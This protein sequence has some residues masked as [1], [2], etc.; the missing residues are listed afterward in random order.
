[1][2]GFQYIVKLAVY[3][4]CVLYIYA[5]GLS[6]DEIQHL[7]YSN[8]RFMSKANFNSCK[9]PRR[10]ERKHTT[11]ECAD[12]RRLQARKVRERCWTE[13]RTKQQTYLGSFLSDSFP[14]P[15]CRH[16]FRAR[17]WEYREGNNRRS[18]RKPDQGRAGRGG[19]RSS[20]RETAVD[21]NREEMA[22]RVA[23][24]QAD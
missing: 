23:R 8:S 2:A 13:I 22:D 5:V 10:Q 17:G 19:N 24:H 14:P 6:V 9:K 7:F 20:G 21:E 12:V 4:G 3:I 16:F 11:R 1:M 18:G 15:N